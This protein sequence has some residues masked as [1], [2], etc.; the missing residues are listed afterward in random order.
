M[1]WIIAL[2]GGVL[3]TWWVLRK[4]RNKGEQVVYPSADSLIQPLA[5]DAHD[6]GER[7]IPVAHVVNFREVGGYKTADGRTVKRGVLYRSG[8]LDKLTQ[9]GLDSLQARGIQ[10]VFDFRSVE[11]STPAPDILPHGVTYY[12]LPLATEDKD[13]QLERLRALLFNKAALRDMMLK[14]YRDVVVD[15]NAQVFGTVINHIAQAE[16]RPALIHCTAG[17]DRTGVAVALI[18]ALLGVPDE[19]II[20]DYTL[21]NH[22][23][24]DYY[25]YAQK[26]IGRYSVL[27]IRAD[28]LWP[29]LVS[30]PRI[31]AGTL[32]HIRERYGSIEAYLQDAAGVT[33]EA[34]EQ[35][36]AELVA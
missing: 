16:N 23:Y 36:R 5:E 9:A 25:A 11:E 20:A 28:D 19:T 2:L 15:R 21:S 29:V 8:G 12:P 17:K 13:N 30:E 10:C 3:G 6:G 35:L 32:A 22:H 4:T 24:N 18:L 26:A 33:A 7:F 34:I 1:R 31:M 14:L 27:G